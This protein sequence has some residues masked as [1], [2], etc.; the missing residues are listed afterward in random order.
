MDT[1]KIFEATKMYHILLKMCTLINVN[2]DLS[3][4][5]KAYPFWIADETSYL[6][7]LSVLE[8]DYDEFMSR[9][10]TRS[11]TV[12]MRYAIKEVLEL[13]LKHIPDDKIEATID[14][15]CVICLFNEA[16]VKLKCNHTIVCQ[17]CYNIMGMRSIRTCP[18]CKCEY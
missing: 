6:C 2:Y 7:F 5:K 4:F 14:T 1:T 18:L 11:V 13:L 3:D 17:K 15:R 9:R 16:S 10:M 8:K 12:N